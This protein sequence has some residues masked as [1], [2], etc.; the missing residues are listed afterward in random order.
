MFPPAQPRQEQPLHPSDGIKPRAAVK[1]SWWVR[2]GRC[3]LVTRVR[4]EGEL[5]LGQCGLVGLEEPPGGSG[6]RGL[7][8]SPWSWHQGDR[9]TGGGSSPA[10][11]RHCPALSDAGQT[12]QSMHESE[13]DRES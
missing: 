13:A 10:Q 4:G 12:N 7:A 2:T 6:K 1:K 11:G 5:V 9:D 8:V 3:A